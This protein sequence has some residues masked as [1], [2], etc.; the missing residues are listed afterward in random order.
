M[1]TQVVLVGAGHTHV[2][3][4]PRIARAARKHNAK[5]TLV[6]GE[7][8]TP[9][10]GLLPGVI[11]GIIPRRRLSLNV[12]KL[13]RRYQVDY[14]EQNVISLDPQ[15]R[16]VV[17]ETGATINYD[18]LSINIGG[19]CDGVIAQEGGDVMPVKPVTPFLDWLENWRDY[20]R[21]T[22][23]VVGAGIAGTEVAMSIDARLRK[24]GRIGGVYIVGR[25]PELIPHRPQL[26]AKMQNLLEKRGI[27]QV[28]GAPASAAYP[29]QLQLANG[30]EHV[31]DHVVVCSGV[32]PWAGLAAAGLE[33]DEHGFVLVTQ[34]LQSVS[35]PDIL[36]CGDCATVV[37]SKFPKSGVFAVRQA[38]TLAA[39]MLA[40][41]SHQR[42]R[43]WQTSERAL[44]IICL[45]D[46]TAVA[47]RHGGK[48]LAGRSVWWWKCYL[49][50][51][52]MRKFT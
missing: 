43:A 4:L 28:L 26:A 35:H 33:V 21:T 27:S 8:Y 15:L 19:N 12:A 41:L 11:A 29:G 50:N 22:C 51:R 46:H 39:N 2:L 45:G 23:A 49:D 9:Y 16:Q 18:H 32:R 6:C 31:A 5:V 25:N 30:S 47:H 13:A 37:G 36:A 20:K 3:A 34:K 52:F 48:V 38:E 17:V 1:T 40:K 42:M 14:I 44:A 10:S 7:A 24:R